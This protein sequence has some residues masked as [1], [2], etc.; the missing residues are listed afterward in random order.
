MAKNT[1][2]QAVQQNDGEAKKL[3]VDARFVMRSYE[4]KDGKD[5][6]YVS[7]ELV[8][9]FNDEDFRDVSLKA[10]WDKLDEKTGRLTRPD[11]VFGW[12]SFYAQKALRQNAEVPVKVTIT[13]VTYK[14]KKSG[15]MVTYPAMYA[16]PTFTELSDE[17]SVEVVVKGAKEANVFL[18]LAS[19][20]LGIRF[21]PRE[22][23][24]DDDSGLMD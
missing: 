14:S 20:A 10:R 2:T 16:E 11:R 15:S 17:R 12:M 18:L 5:V 4:G 13:P 21:T 6:N 9:P 7:F 1:N 8:D 19:N 24:D 22:N 23:P 3:V